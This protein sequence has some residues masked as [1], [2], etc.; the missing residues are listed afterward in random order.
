MQGGCKL[1]HIS[2]H[3]TVNILFT[4]QIWIIIRN[5]SRLSEKM[6]ENVCFLNV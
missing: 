5:G 6:A 2:I 4:A 3:S 1:S